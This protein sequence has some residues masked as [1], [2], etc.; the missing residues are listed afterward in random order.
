M[1]L[2][3]KTNNNKIKL[4]E[5]KKEEKVKVNER[6]HQKEDQQEKIKRDKY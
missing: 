6:R 3:K 5:V 1:S 4:L 2:F